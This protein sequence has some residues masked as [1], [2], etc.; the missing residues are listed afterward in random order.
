M[1]AEIAA[2]VINL[3]IL[4]C[5]TFY[6]PYEPVCCITSMLHLLGYGPLRTSVLQAIRDRQLD[7]PFQKI[8]TGKYRR[9]FLLRLAAASVFQVQLPIHLRSLGPI[10]GEC[11]AH[12]T[13][14]R[15]VAVERQRH[16]LRRRAPRITNNQL[17]LS[18][19]PA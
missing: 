3:S 14:Y 16:Q 2:V 11:G 15:P 6:L 1:F 10:R 18:L 4:L 17:S 5:A 19:L 8:S 12:H 7:S 13:G 9:I